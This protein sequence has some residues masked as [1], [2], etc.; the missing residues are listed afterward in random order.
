MHY[1]RSLKITSFQQSVNG[2]G[3]V[4]LFFVIDFLQILHPLSTDNDLPLQH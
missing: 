4:H 1:M 2:K 3:I